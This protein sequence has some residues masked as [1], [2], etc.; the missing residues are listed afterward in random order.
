MVNNT[1]YYLDGRKYASE[2]RKNN[3]KSACSFEKLISNSQ[4]N[5]LFNL[6]NSYI[7]IDPV[8]PKFYPRI[9]LENPNIEGCKDFEKK[10]KNFK[11]IIDCR[12]PVFMSSQDLKKNSSRKEI[13]PFINSFEFNDLWFIRDLIMRQLEIEK[14]QFL[15][16]NKFFNIFHFKNGPF[17]FTISMC[18]SGGKCYPGYF[19]PEEHMDYLINYRIFSKIMIN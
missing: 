7:K 12:Q 6:I 17:P 2:L 16:N 3:F 5:D 4:Q 8:D 1:D 9:L 14:G 13:E 10:F 15:M 11:K 18:F 19:T